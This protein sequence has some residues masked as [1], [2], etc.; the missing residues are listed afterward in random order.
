MGRLTEKVG[1]LVK[2]GERLAES[3]EWLIAINR[4]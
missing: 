4:E 1:R 2:S 3:D